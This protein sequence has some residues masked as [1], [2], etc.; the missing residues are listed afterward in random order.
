MGPVED[1]ASRHNSTIFKRKEEAERFLPG[2]QY[3]VRD[4][5]VYSL[6]SLVYLHWDKAS[7]FELY[8]FYCS[9]PMVC[10][11]APHSRG[12]AASLARRREMQDIEWRLYAAWKGG[13]K[14]KG[15]KGKEER[16]PSH[17]TWKGRQGKG[18]R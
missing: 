4:A 5:S 18:R 13:G 3:A 8:T 10:Y 1:M 7:I 9:C 17:A 12:S 2:C 16:P 14:D 15:K 6:A 11:K